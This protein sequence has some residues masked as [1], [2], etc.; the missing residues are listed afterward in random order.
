MRTPTSTN[1]LAIFAYGSLLFRPGFSYLD[2]VRAIAHGRARSFSQ[3]SP[4]HRGTPDLPGRVLT[5]VDAPGAAT[6][7]A[8]YLVEPPAA[9]LLAELD[10][11]ERAG[12]RRITL[13]V[14][15]TE[16]TLSAVTWI[17]EPGN[18]HHVDPLP[19]A[20]LARLIR[21]ATGP[22]GR[23]DEYVLKVAGALDELEA[24]DPMISALAALLR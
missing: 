24:D 1:R 15:T 17:A 9:E 2:R 4:D 7:G 13:E 5:L 16:G 20:E 10:H 11:R 21:T 19:L 3:A 22:S 8:V 23:N 14:E 6:V 18:E 12:Y